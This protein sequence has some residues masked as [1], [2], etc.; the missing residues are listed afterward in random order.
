[1]KHILLATTLLLSACANQQPK[2]VD[3]TTEIVYPYHEDGV[4]CY[5]LAYKGVVVSSGGQ[6]IAML[7]Q[8]Y[9]NNAGG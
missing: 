5:G 1:M 4:I 7:V 6:C 3:R 8:T 2:T 9:I